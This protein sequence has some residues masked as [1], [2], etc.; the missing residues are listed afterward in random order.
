MCYNTNW[1]GWALGLESFHQETEEPPKLSPWDSLPHPSPRP[2]DIMERI[3]EE[4]E[5][6][7]ITYQSDQEASVLT[8]SWITAMTGRLSVTT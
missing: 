1:L 4:C 3:G 2:A 6:Y 5:Q 7:V 8:L